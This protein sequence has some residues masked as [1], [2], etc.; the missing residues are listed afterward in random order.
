MSKFN[1]YYQAVN[2]PVG[3]LKNVSNGTL[4]NEHME[5]LQAT[6]P[7]LLSEMQ[8]K[9]V[10]KMTDPEKIRQL[11]YAQ[12]LSLAKFIN[13]PLD[14]NMVP[15][16]IM[17]NQAAMN[18][19]QLSQQTSGAVKPSQKGLEKLSLSKRTGTMGRG[20]REEA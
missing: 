6:S 7:K 16:V 4:T 11:P 3:T 8:D 18:A 17:S 1:Q 12:K 14:E 19:P 5:A 9:V 20:E 2:D 15:A 10:E 13:Q